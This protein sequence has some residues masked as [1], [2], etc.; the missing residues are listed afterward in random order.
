MPLFELELNI[1]KDYKAILNKYLEIIAI[2][3]IYIFLMEADPK[4][5]I[6]DKTLYIVLGIT[7]YY[8]IVKKIV[9]IT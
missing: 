3:I 7:F 2:A 4:S 6:L 5:T 8:L 1:P 9:K